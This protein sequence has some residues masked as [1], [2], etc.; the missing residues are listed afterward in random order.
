M[1]LPEFDPKITMKHPFCAHNA[2]PERLAECTIAWSKLAENAVKNRKAA[3]IEY[4]KNQ[5]A[6]ESCKAELA[7]YKKLEKG[8]PFIYDRFPKL[9]GIV[10]I[11]GPSRAELEKKHA[12]L[13]SL[14]DKACRDYIK[15]A[16]LE[17]WCLYQKDICDAFCEFKEKASYE[18]LYKA[19]WTSYMMTPLRETMRTMEAQIA[20][21]KGLVSN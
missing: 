18:E 17:R 8:L 14:E 15:A 16:D 21:W 9:E 11:T 5:D 10:V 2:T 7:E 13:M 6:L 1:S 4:K 3:D 19:I 12:E 20:F